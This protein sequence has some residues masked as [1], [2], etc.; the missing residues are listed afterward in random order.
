M[1]SVVLPAPVLDVQ[2]RG[3]DDLLVTLTRLVSA[4][5]GRV[6]VLAGMG[7]CGKSTVARS[8]A[9]LVKAR[10][11]KAWWVQATDG[12]VLTQLLLGLA[13]ELGAPAGQ[14]AAA[15]EGRVNPSDVLWGQLEVGRGW[16]LVLDNADDLTALTVAGRSAAGGSGWLRSSKSGLVLVTSR[17]LD[18]QAWGPVTEVCPMQSLDVADGAQVLLDLAPDAGD[19][20]AA[21]RLSERLG[22]LPLAL[23]HAGCYLA[24]PFA[25]ESSF[26][27]YEQVLEARFGDL[28]DRGGGDRD[29]V[30]ATW[31]LSLDA[32]AAPGKDQARPL[33]RLLSCF[34]SSVPVPP[35][36]LDRARLATAYHGARA[37]E[38][39]LAGLLAVGLISIPGMPAGHDPGVKVH[40][41]VAQTVRYRA[42]DDLTS[43]LAEAVRLL[44]AAM[45]GLSPDNPKQAADWVNLLPHLQALQQARQKLPGEAEESLVEAAAEMTHALMWAHSHAALL[46]VAESGLAREHGLGSNH[47]AVLRLRR[48][49]ANA[50]RD[51][52][53][54]DEAEAEYRRV[55]SAQAPL[56]GPDHPDTLATQYDLA[57]AMAAQGKSAEAEAECRQVLGARLRALGSEHPDVLATRREIARAMAAQGRPAEAEGEFRQV[58]NAQQRVRGSDHP[59]VLAS[60]YD[61]ARAIAAQ[62]K[63]AE[64]E[65]EFRQ[66]LDARQ[67]ILGPD[68]PATLTTRQAIAKLLAA[69]GR[70]AEAEVEVRQTLDAQQRILGP[71]H[72]DTL[73]TL[74]LLDGLRNS[75]VPDTGHS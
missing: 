7:G 48:H 62:G 31:E 1:R 36:V 32:L 70:R 64:A 65:A 68:H 44:A 34:A 37:V 18:S 46:A 53:R 75:Q 61:L 56:L 19:R 50:L 8:V 14:V 4:P 16:L 55:S 59:D 66:V 35:Q 57:R 38:D 23:H 21:E 5:D 74:S 72:P 13:E 26:A 54:Y 60:Q 28:M 51:L 42:G 24:S 71:D 15:L 17:T 6:R 20:N 2:V 58:I 9:A 27:V 43:Y 3:R 49:R 30:I 33:L 52:G 29:T 10:G 39:G 11:G 73:I 12:A 47:P 67:R 63:S 45:G 69:E 41:L 40:P 22:G 25:A